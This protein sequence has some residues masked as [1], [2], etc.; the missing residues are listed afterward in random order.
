MKSMEWLELLGRKGR[1]EH[2][3]IKHCKGIGK[4]NLGKLGN[5]WRGLQE[6]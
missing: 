1:L 3:S 4:V 6:F 5:G 2:L